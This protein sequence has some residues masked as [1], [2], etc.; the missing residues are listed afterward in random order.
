[1]PWWKSCL[2]GAG[3][4]L[5]GAGAGVWLLNLY[6]EAWTRRD[7]AQG[8]NNGPGIGTAG[9]MLLLP[10][11][12]IGGALSLGLT[13]LLRKNGMGAAVPYLAAAGWILL[14]YGFWKLSG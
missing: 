8:G 7:A 2:V 14:L 6:I 11:L 9:I 4:F 12:L 3:T 10:V 13:A 1:M 5:L